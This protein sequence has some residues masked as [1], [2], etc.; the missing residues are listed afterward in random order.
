MVQAVPKH[1]RGHGESYV[2]CSCPRCAVAQVQG[3]GNIS[4]CEK[5]EACRPACLDESLEGERGQLEDLVRL[6]TYIFHIVCNQQHPGTERLDYPSLSNTEANYF[7]AKNSSSSC[8][9]LI[10]WSKWKTW[11]LDKK[12]VRWK[13]KG[14]GHFQAASWISCSSVVLQH[15]IPRKESALPKSGRSPLARG[16]RTHLIL[17]EHT[18]EDPS[19]TCKE[20]LETRNSKL[21]I[22]RAAEG[23]ERTEIFWRWQFRISK[24]RPQD[25]SSGSWPYQ[26]PWWVLWCRWRKEEGTT[27]HGNGSPSCMA[28]H[29]HM[30]WGCWV[31]G[32]NV[33]HEN[34]VTDSKSCGTLVYNWGKQATGKIKISGTI[35]L[36]ATQPKETLI[37]PRLDRTEPHHCPVTSLWELADHQLEMSF[38]RKKPLCYNRAVQ[39]QSG[40]FADK[41]KNLWRTQE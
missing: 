9:C 29:G 16:R 34:S 13:K 17:P 41:Y 25:C 39:S 26:R 20:P 30:A 15:C 35:N 38:W 2:M 33:A 4:F 19:W 6:G 36:I 27:C 40:N 7:C 5:R 3:A 37:N 31:R 24:K 28:A 11:R 8:F 14:Q 21:H 23:R 1:G 10:P 18:Q 12:C 32:L 22:P